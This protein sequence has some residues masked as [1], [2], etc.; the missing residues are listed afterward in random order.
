MKPD[1]IPEDMPE[2]IPEDMPENIS[3][4]DSE[5]TVQ[6]PNLDPAFK[7]E[8]MRNEG[9]GGL[10]YCFACG[11]CTASCPI[12]EI[13]HGFDPRKLA[14]MVQLGMKDEVLSSP[15]IWYCSACRN[16]EQHCPQ[17]VEF[18]NILNVLKNMAAEKGY[19]PYAW[20]VQT[21]HLMRTGMVFRTDEAWETRR[22]AL[23]LPPL[24]LDGEKVRELIELSGLDELIVKKRP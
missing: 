17:S 2:D 8:V 6:V 7:Y 1:D 24:Q 5:E 19:A 15:L 16:C 12:H 3:G 18:F 10:K 23:S 13:D 22:K 14:R 20:V 9:A 21:R 11:A 4:D